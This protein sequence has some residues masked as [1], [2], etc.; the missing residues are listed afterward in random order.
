M[1]VKLKTT[2]FIAYLQ[3]LGITLW[4]EEDSLRFSARQ[5]ELTPALRTELVE[6]KLEILNLLRSTNPAEMSLTASDSQPLFV[7][8]RTPTEEI[9]AQVW[10]RMLGIE[11]VG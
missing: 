3:G 4:A 5:G 2:D 11:K 9:L 6:R 7:A 10:Q 8:P 1:S